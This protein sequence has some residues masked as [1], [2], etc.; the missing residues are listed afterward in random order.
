MVTTKRI[1]KATKTTK[2]RAKAAAAVLEQLFG[3]VILIEGHTIGAY[4]G[5]HALVTL[6]DKPGVTIAVL[7]KLHWLQ[8]MLE[9][10]L[11]T[12]N[13]VAITGKKLASPP[14]SF[15]VDAYSVDGV[16]LYNM[17]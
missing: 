1:T 3:H 8:T 5:V 7:T 17:V 9:K 14:L 4:K 10:A 15:T 12:G 13:L 2:P 11:S 16:I 6:R